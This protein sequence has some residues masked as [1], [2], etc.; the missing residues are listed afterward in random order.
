MDR[1]RPQVYLGGHYEWYIELDIETLKITLGMDVLRCKTP[2]M[3]V[4]EIWA[5]LLAY[6]LIR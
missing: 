1:A 3:A 5:C 2:A 6:N 4:K